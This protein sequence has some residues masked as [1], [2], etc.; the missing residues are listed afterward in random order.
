[1]MRESKRL[2]TLDEMQKFDVS[3][4]LEL[5]RTLSAGEAISFIGNSSGLRLRNVSLPEYNNESYLHSLDELGEFLLSAE[6]VVSKGVVD[7][8]AWHIRRNCT[9]HTLESEFKRL[10][11]TIRTE[12]GQQHFYRM[13]ESERV[14][15]QPDPEHPIFGGAVQDKFPSALYEIDESAKCLALER[16]TATVFHL[17]RAMERVL[18]AIRKCL[19]LPDPTRLSDKNWGTILRDIRLE[20]ERRNKPGSLA[21]KNPEDQHLFADLVGSIAAVKLAWRDTTMHVESKYLASE[22]QEIFAAVRTLMQKIASRMDEEG[23]PLA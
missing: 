8:I 9:L 23:L 11:S 14:L 5:V 10:L 21:W 15:F 20:V 2:Y 16:T 18:I 4:I 12:I 7:K 3:R 22:A 19:G 17:M 13:T 1:M 6:L